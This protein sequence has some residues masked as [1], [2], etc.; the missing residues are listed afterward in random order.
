MWRPIRLERMSERAWKTKDVAEFLQASE[1]PD[2]QGAFSLLYRSY[3]Q[4]QL[5]KP[6]TIGLRYTHYNLLPETATFVARA[7]GTSAQST[8]VATAPIPSTAA[9]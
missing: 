8:G 3:L 1:W 6:N 4:R 7:E 2:V 5:I 9:M